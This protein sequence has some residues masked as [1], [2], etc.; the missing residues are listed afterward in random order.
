MS[1]STGLKILTTSLCCPL[2]SPSSRDDR[3]MRTLVWVRLEWVGE[4]IAAW[5]A[6]C[7]CIESECDRWIGALLWSDTIVVFKLFLSA[8]Y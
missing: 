2:E 3:T 5:F 7:K 4:R 1:T 6:I 8:S